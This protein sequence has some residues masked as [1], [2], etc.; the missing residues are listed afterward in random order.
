M[1]VQFWVFCFWGVFLLFCFLLGG[2]G[3]GIS[4]FFVLVLFFSCAEVLLMDRGAPNLLVE[5]FRSLQLIF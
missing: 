1:S 2:R 4:W 5:G 3:G